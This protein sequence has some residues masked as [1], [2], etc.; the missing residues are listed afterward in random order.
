MKGL[1]APKVGILSVH[2]HGD[3]SFLDDQ[4]FALVSGQLRD[5]GIANYL[6][7]V[8]LEG[9][10]DPDVEAALARTL[11]PYQVVVYERV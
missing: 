4:D 3:R 6:V 9:G 5:A 7:V 1:A 8:V 10:A 2:S 11:E